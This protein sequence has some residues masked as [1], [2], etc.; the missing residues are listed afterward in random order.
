MSTGARAFLT[1]ER[2]RGGVEGYLWVQ[3]V[4]GIMICAAAWLLMRAVGLQ[5][6]EFWTFVIFIVGF[7]PVL[8][9]AIA[10]CAP[11]LFALV[12]FPTYWQAIVLFFGLQT[13]L[14][15]VGNLIQDGF[16]GDSNAVTLFD[17]GGQTPLTPGSKL[18]LAR[19]IVAR[20]AALL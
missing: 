5:N 15:I 6:A 3:A 17:D 16:G 8:G 20:I 7:I 11:P 4:T 14:F 9:G 2:V 1:F 19:A 18:E 12:Q 13:I 10:G